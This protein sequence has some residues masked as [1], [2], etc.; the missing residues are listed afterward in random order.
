[1]AADPNSAIT[2][3]IVAELIQHATGVAATPQQINAWVAS[4]LTVDQ[5]LST[6]RKRCG[7][8]TFHLVA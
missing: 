5:A 8:S 3:A 1:V 4:A 6:L 2:A 7:D